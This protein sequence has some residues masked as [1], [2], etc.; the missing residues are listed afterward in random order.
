MRFVSDEWHWLTDDTCSFS[1]GGK[2]AVGYSTAAC[3]LVN[4]QAVVL[5]GRMLTLRQQ[6]RSGSRRLA[7]CM[8]AARGVSASQ[9]RRAA[10]PRSGRRTCCDAAARAGMLSKASSDIRG[11]EHAPK[12]SRLPYALSSSFQRLLFFRVGLISRLS[13]CLKRSIVSDRQ[14][15]SQEDNQ[16]STTHA[17]C[18]VLLIAST[19]AFDFVRTS[20]PPAQCEATHAR[21]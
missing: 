9:T 15:D 18:H 14:S 21:H 12:L 17:L 13:L 20:S 11:D 7:E 1:K 5:T 16:A 2:A 3:R 6:W 4:K 10:Q 19:S 8:A